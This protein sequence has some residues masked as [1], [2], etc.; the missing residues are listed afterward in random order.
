MLT[1]DQAHLDVVFRSLFQSV[2]VSLVNGQ[3]GKG[4]LSGVHDQNGSIKLRYYIQ[5][6]KKVYEPEKILR[7]GDYIRIDIR[8]P[9]KLQDIS[10]KTFPKSSSRKSSKESENLEI[11]FKFENV[12]YNCDTE[13][14]SKSGVSRKSQRSYLSGKTIDKG[15]RSD[16]QIEK[17]KSDTGIET[18]EFREGR[19]LISRDVGDSQ[20]KGT[21]SFGGHCS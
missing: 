10:T 8:D 6:D 15:C 14:K 16:V 3:R 18:D 1:Q 12:S 5:S 20:R 13:D 17:C 2:E 19:R 21:T 4:F 7:P 11:G 9:R